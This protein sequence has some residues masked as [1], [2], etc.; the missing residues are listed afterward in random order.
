MFALN[1]TFLRYN[2]TVTL[3]ERRNSKMTVKGTTIYVTE[4][5]IKAAKLGVA[6]VSELETALLL[7]GYELEVESINGK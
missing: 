7:A 5:E 1:L 2:V 4:K 3:K 6:G